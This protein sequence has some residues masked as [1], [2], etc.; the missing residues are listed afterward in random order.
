MSLFRLTH[1]AGMA[2]FSDLRVTRA[3][4]SPFGNINK[5]TTFTIGEWVAKTRSGVFAGM[6]TQFFGSFSFNIAE[7][8]SLTFGN[9]VF[10]FFVSTSITDLGGA[11][12]TRFFSVLGEWTPGGFGGVAGGPFACQMIFSFSQT[13]SNTGFI[14]AGATFSTPPPATIPEVASWSLLGISFA[15]IAGDA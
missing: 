14:C 10:G 1:F 3:D 5:A 6:P 7:P 2:L 12:G 8:R 4:G 15:A 9:S 11:P 13:P